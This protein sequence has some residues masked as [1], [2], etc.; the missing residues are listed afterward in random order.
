MSHELRLTRPVKDAPKWKRNPEEKVTWSKPRASRTRR[1][2]GSEGLPLAT[3]LQTMS[4]VHETEEMPSPPQQ[5]SRRGTVRPLPVPSMRKIAE[6]ASLEYEQVPPPCLRATSVGP[7]PL[8]PCDFCWPPA[9]APLPPTRHACS[10][11]WVRREARQ[12]GPK[13]RETRPPGCQSRAKHALCEG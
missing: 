3:S 10:T 4:T 1:V 6:T 8:P 7:S 13:A 9:R 2:T 12:A 5:L 11:P